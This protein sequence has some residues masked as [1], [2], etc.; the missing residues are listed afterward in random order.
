MKLT[1][2][3]NY[4]TEWGESLFM[5]GSAEALGANDMDKAVAMK[6]SGSETWTAEVELPDTVTNFTYAYFVRHDNGSTRREWGHPRAFTRSEHLQSAL[7]FDRWQ[8]QPWDKPYYAASFVDCICRRDERDQPQLPAPG[9]FTLSVDAPMI[10]PD[11]YVA[12]C[13]SVEAMGAWKPEKA[14]RMTDAAY[15]TWTVNIPVVDVNGG[16]EYKYLIVKKNTA[17]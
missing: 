7:I 5:T 4:R 15:P 2:S 8:D 12:V 16:A 10:A 6:L 11:E 17:T 9:F 14:L 13:G 1:F 3:V